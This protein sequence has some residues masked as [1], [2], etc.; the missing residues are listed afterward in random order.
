MNNITILQANILKYIKK[1]K[2]IKLIKATEKLLLTN[3]EMLLK[4]YLTN[5]L[6]NYDKT[7]HMFYIF[8]QELFHNISL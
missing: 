6:K 4:D 1:T 5:L 7:C 2:N 3:P 8:Y